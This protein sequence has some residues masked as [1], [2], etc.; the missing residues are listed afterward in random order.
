MTIGRMVRVSKS[1]LPYNAGQKGPIRSYFRINLHS[2]S[3]GNSEKVAFLIQ[4]DLQLLKSILMPENWRQVAPHFDNCTH[5][6]KS[7]SL[8]ESCARMLPR[9]PNLFFH[10]NICFQSSH[11]KVLHIAQ[12]PIK[13]GALS[14]Q[15]FMPM[16]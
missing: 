13:I 7:T 16:A 10:I 11:Y 3:G 6:P 2:T 9:H 5:I 14:E 15:L 12:C 1:T 4:T 8:L